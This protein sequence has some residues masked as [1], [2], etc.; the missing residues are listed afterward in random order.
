[1]ANVAFYGK[2]LTSGGQKARSSSPKN[3]ERDF[4]RRGKP[5]PR[6]SAVSC[7]VVSLVVVTVY[8]AATRFNQRLCIFGLCGAIQMLL[9]LL[10]RQVKLFLRVPDRSQPHGV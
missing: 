10:L 4:L 3:Q 1:M 2:L 8:I 5:L 9:L 7:P 6:R